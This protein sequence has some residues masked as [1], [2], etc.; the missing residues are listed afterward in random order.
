MYL[1]A[2]RLFILYTQRKRILSLF[3]I[4]GYFKHMKY[5]ADSLQMCMKFIIFNFIPNTLMFLT[6]K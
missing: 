2:Y 4:L 5:M 1:N 6:S 3:K